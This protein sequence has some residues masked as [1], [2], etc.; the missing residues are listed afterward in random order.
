MI[1]IQGKDIVKS[2]GGLEILKQV[3]FSIN[4]GDKVGVVGSNGAGKTTLFRCLTGD[5]ILD[6]GQVMIGS[7][8]QLKTLKQEVCFTENNTLEDELMTS[9]AHILQLRAEIIKLTNEMEE[10]AHMPAELEKAMT[11]YQI[12]LQNYEEQGGYEIENRVRQVAIGL[13]FAHE[14]LGRVANQFSGGQQ[15]R[16][17]LGKLLLQQ[18]DIL[19]LDE[20]TNHLDTDASEWLE[21]FLKNYQ[22]TVLVISH[23]RYF[24]DEVCDKILEL[25]Q[26]KTKLFRGNYTN[27]KKL[28]AEQ[29]KAYEAA[30]RKQQE[31][32]QETE[33]YIDR[34][35]AGIK[36]KQARGRQ[37]QLERLERMEAI[38]TERS[39]GELQFPMTETTGERVIELDQ[40]SFGYDSNTNVFQQVTGLIR[41]GEKVAIVG[42]NGSGKTTLLKVLVG[43]LKP[44]TGEVSFGSRVKLAYYSQQHDQLNLNNEVL[45][46]VV[47]NSNLG[48]KEARAYLGKFL[49]S[50]EDVFKRVAN[51]SGG[52]K[53]RLALL[54]IFLQGANVLILDEPTNHLDISS[55]EVLERSIKEFPGT[56]V[57]VSH[58]RYFLDQICH[59]ICEFNGESKEGI[60]EYLGNYSYYRYKKQSLQEEETQ[61]KGKE[62]NPVKEKK[63]VGSAKELR[64]KEKEEKR[65]QRQKVREVEELELAITNLEEEKEQVA[66][67]LAAPE[68]YNDGEKAKQLTEQF[69]S[70]EQELTQLYEQWEQLT[71]EL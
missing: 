33:A 44:K 32:I 21:G 43:I 71:E 40:V 66:E 17:N 51:L 24:L 6:A 1:V 54:K 45:Q 60:N 56:V 11:K 70:M 8:L 4:S 27:Y 26:G 53:S 34:Y 38:S 20:P 55:K 10:L 65:L 62:T 59:K 47:Q 63:S 58:D 67:A 49:F 19:L 28:K 30:Y 39:L 37:K 31:H 23:D 68:T 13:G 29:L 12:T 42:A 64:E 9:F 52:E 41:R 46:E 2:Y 14:D 3:T 57:L 35:R 69:A 22:G 61:R 15:T 7:G 36:S 16:I 48:E 25:E 18:P 5:E 50:Q